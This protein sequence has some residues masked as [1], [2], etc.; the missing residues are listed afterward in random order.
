MARIYEWFT[1][2]TIG[3]RKR[4]SEVSFPTSAALNVI[5]I[6]ILKEV[7]Q[8]LMKCGL[9]VSMSL[10]GLIFAEAF[11]IPECSLNVP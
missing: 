11:S 5:Y 6:Y 1:Y 8:Q 2:C 4:A 7:V 9:V 3:C 10:H